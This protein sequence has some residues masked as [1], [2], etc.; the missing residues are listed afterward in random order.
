MQARS[1]ERFQEEA[2]GWE[3]KGITPMSYSCPQD[4]G[5]QTVAYS[6]VLYGQLAKNGFIFLMIVKNKQEN[7]QNTKKN[8]QQ[9]LCGHKVCSVY[10]LALYRKR[11]LRPA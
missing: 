3:N 11:L 1:C 6:L 9:R 8:V 10:C 4:Q 7:K 2:G 5:W